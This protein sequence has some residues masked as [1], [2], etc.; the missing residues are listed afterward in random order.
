MRPCASRRRWPTPLDYAHRHGVIH[1]DIKPENILLHDGRPMVADFGIAL[2]VSAAAGGRMTETGLSLGTPHYMSPEQATAEKEITGRSDVYSLA[3]VLYEMLTGN[4]PHVGATAQQII[5][6][7]ITEQA[8]AVTQFRKS[9]PPNVAAAVAHALEKLPADRFESAAAFAQALGDASFHGTTVAVGG[10]SAAGRA[11]SRRTLIALAAVAVL[12]TGLAAWSLLRAT[13]DG[14]VSRF[15][16][17]LEPGRELAFAGTNEP[18]RLALTPDGRSLIYVADT[19]V[20]QGTRRVLVLRSLDQ[21]ETRLLPGTEDA[22]GP[23]ISWDGTQAAFV[24]FTTS[25]T[26]RVVSLRGGPTLTVADK[27]VESLPTWGPDG[28]VYFI[29]AGGVIRRVS[30]GGGPVEDVLKLTDPGDGRSYHWLRI[31]PDGRGALATATAGENGD[32]STALMR[33]IDLRSGRIGAELQGVG[34]EYVAEARALVYATFDGTLMAVSFDETSLETRG[35]PQALFAG[36]EIRGQETE[37]TVGGGILAYAQEGTN[38]IEQT[39]WVRRDGGTQELVDPTW[40][41]PELESF[42]LSPDGGRLAIS[43]AGRNRTDVWIKQLERGP[44]NRLTFGGTNNDAPSWS[45]DGRTVTYLSVRDGKRTLW[46][47][48][49]DGV[50]AEELVADVGRDFVEA[51]SSRDGAWLVASVEG[52]PS[53]DIFAMKVGT[54]SA[55]RPLLTE[56]WAEWSPALSPDGKWLAYVSNESG[57][58]QVFVRPFPA[59]QDGRWQVSTEGALNPVWSADGR[60]LFYRTEAGQAVNS[61]DMSRGPAS[62]TRRALFRSTP[63]G[64]FEINITDQMFSPSRDG[65]RFLMVRQG[66]GDTSGDLVI[67]QNFITELRAALKAGARQ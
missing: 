36:A 42:A 2:A 65:K 17:N 51:R 10:V 14:P 61:A 25:P 22:I 66:T 46:R 1:R 64:R 27:G 38:A 55:L 15:L 60:E 32:G 62:L 35:R 57:Q 54:D 67:V 45:A 30:G 52:P 43:I 20:A 24:I 58:P 6:K 23:A 13:P 49:A 50:G 41:D 63:E 8:P 47:R 59:V 12:S 28:F 39:I 21:F 3:S 40:A 26:I 19:L 56:S 29:G 16:V 37:L 18:P 4:P 31:L 9:V 7:I 44:L 11:T 33:A 34:G 53:R 48:R 5:M